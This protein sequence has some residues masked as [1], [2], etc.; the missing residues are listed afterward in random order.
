MFSMVGSKERNRRAEDLIGEGWEVGPS[1]RDSVVGEDGSAGNGE[2]GRRSWFWGYALASEVGEVEGG[3]REQ[4]GHRGRRLS[5]G[6]FC[7]Q[8]LGLPSPWF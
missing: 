4:H 6:R 5:A 8:R 1:G 7:E 2:R 3:S